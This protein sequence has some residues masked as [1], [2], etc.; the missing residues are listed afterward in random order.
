[1]F[2]RIP[3]GL[4]LIREKIPVRD[5]HLPSYVFEM[6]LEKMLEE[7]VRHRSEGYTMSGEYDVHN[8][9]IDKMTDLFLETLRSWGPTS[10]LR[11]RIQ[12]QRY[13][14]QNLRKNVSSV[15]SIKQAEKDLQRRISQTAFGVLS[16]AKDSTSMI[17]D[18]T[19][20]QAIDSSKDS[21]FDVD[22]LIAKFSTRLQLNGKSISQ[23]YQSSNIFVGRKSD[24][25]VIFANAELEMMRERF[26]RALG[27]FLSI[28]SS[29]MTESLPLLEETAVLT[30]NHSREK[31]AL[32]EVTGSKYDHVLSLIEMHRLQYILLS[33][34]YS[35]VDKSEGSTEPPIV[36]LIMLV[37]LSKAGSFLIDCLSLPDTR[38]DA[39]G[40]ESTTES[41][42]SNLPLD[43][44]ATQLASRPK[45][46]YWFLFQVFTKRPD[47]YVK[48][49]TTSVPPLTITNLHRTQF[50]LFLDY[51]NESEGEVISEPMVS[52]SV[53]IDSDTP[54]MSFLRATIPHGGVDAMNV[55]E[56]LG[57]YRGGRADSPV[58]AREL[59][60]VIEKFGKGTLVEAK[61]ILTLYLLGA[62]SLSMAV[63]FAERDTKHSKDLWEMLLEHCTT[64]DPSSDANE[65]GALFGS[66]LEA[67][68]HCG[69][70][71]ASLVSSIPE[72]MSI[73]GLRPKLI[74]AIAD[75]RHKVQIHKYTADA[76]V[77]DKVSLLRE[78]CHLSRRGRRAI[79]DRKVSNKCAH[80]ND[81]ASSDKLSL[82]Q[83]QRTKYGATTTRHLSSFSLSIR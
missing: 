41:N 75:Y 17:E 48:F 9:A 15:A 65:K 7:T 55:R 76:L 50:S 44:I 57:S 61:E 81:S 4:F 32:A 39:D 23:D 22:N 46:L 21:L 80:K 58:F 25:T 49:P 31:L 63:A 59:A 79:G 51:A 82:L 40:V 77:E 16:D 64:S 36:A 5:P 56:S 27:Y 54:F 74:A 19:S 37:G 42:D 67:A 20:R 43:A 13:N 10:C 12:L 78:L 62:K 14:G 68:A 6:V 52:T 35:F 47:M 3:G 60:F 45:L 2:A 11:K 1:M 73:E 28:G 30:V 72:G 33:R 26:D 69:A 66:L 24:V 29:F 38:L 53:T 18:I 70:D 83:M 8:V 34:N 71:L